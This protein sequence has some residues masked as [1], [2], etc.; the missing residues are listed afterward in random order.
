MAWWDG[1][2]KVSAYLAYDALNQ[3]ERDWVMQLIQQN[4]TYQELFAEKIAIELPA[5]TDPQTIQRWHFGQASVWADLVRNKSD[6]ASQTDQMLQ[7]LPF[8]L[9]LVLW[10]AAVV[11]VIYVT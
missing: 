10:V 1:G 11:V 3:A 6:A 2:H 7:D 5:E 4:P 9:N 8:L